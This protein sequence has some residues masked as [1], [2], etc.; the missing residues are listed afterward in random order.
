M[1]D[2]QE[3]I[4]KRNDVDAVTGKLAAV[5]VQAFVWKI[6]ICLSARLAAVSDLYRENLHNE[7]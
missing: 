1:N 3:E 6:T 4:K 7:K 2:I 5:N